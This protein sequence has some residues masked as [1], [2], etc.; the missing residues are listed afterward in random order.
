[1]VK[2]VLSLL[3]VLLLNS[4]FFIG[5]KK[6]YFSQSEI[7]INNG[8]K[9]NGYYYSYY[10]EKND[11]LISPIVYL[12]LDDGYFREEIYE[13]ALGKYDYTM[14]KGS[15]LKS[16]DNYLLLKANNH[17]KHLFKGSAINRW[18]R[19]TIK[20][21]TLYVRHFTQDRNKNYYVVEINGINKLKEN[22]IKFF[23]GHDF[24]HN[25]YFEYEKIY[26]FRKLDSLSFPVPDVVKKIK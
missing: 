22:K 10:L 2:K 6:Y 20:G 19:Y 7:N 15:H 12:F 23:K 4:C 16:I 8:P 1:M 11:T 9:K 18:S 24:Q 17:K 13:Y 5:G 26:H 3:F 25:R 21:D 14:S